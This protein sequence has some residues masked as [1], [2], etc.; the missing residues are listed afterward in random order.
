M[1]ADRDVD[2]ISTVPGG[3]SG[4]DWTAVYANPFSRFGS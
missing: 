4:A 3:K 2:D 1:T